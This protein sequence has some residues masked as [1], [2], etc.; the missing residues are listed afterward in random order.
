MLRYPQ[1]AVSSNFCK[2]VDNE[3]KTGVCHGLNGVIM[4]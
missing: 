4:Y 2:D 3:M 1:I